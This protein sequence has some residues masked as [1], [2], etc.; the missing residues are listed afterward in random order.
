MRRYRLAPILTLAAALLPTPGSPQTEG[1][2]IEVRGVVKDVSGAAVPGALVEVSDEQGRLLASAVAG[3]DG[4]FHFTVDSAVHE[5]TLEVRASGFAKLVRSHLETKD[6]TKDMIMELQV[7]SCFPCP[8]VRAVPSLGSAPAFSDGTQLKASDLSD[9]SGGGGYSDSASATQ[10][11]LVRDYAGAVT[12]R[13]DMESVNLASA[14]P[15]EIDRYGSSLLLR[16]NFETAARVFER[17]VERYPQSGKLQL[18]LGTARYGQGRYEDAVRAWLAA[19]ETGTAQV[20]PEDTVGDARATRTTEAQ[21]CMFLAKASMSATALPPEQRAEIA[22]RLGHFAITN[23]ENATAHYYYGVAVLRD[24]GEARRAD[25]ARTE[26][27]KAVSRDPGLADPHF[28]LGNLAATE[29]RDLEA[30]REYREAIR[31]RPDFAAAHYRLAQVYQRVGEKFK[32]QA[33]LEAW[34]KLR[35][36]SGGTM[37]P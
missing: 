12:A 30:I 13:E 26:F 17:G 23:P 18:G 4:T 25:L 37:K 29:H 20:R 28:E 33:E 14:S 7:G 34:E 31:L 5:Y 8:T 6:V 36:G 32:G 2:T 3:T 11:E 19:T 10:S 22:T 1:R 24:P 27:A 9:P 15:K 16:Q 35:G 21:A